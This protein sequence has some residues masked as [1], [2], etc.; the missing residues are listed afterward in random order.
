MLPRSRRLRF[1]H[2]RPLA[3]AHLSVLTD[4][5]SKAGDMQ[6]ED[7]ERRHYMEVGRWKGAVYW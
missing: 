7:L 5:A 3:K 2:I 6:E 1:L 4:M